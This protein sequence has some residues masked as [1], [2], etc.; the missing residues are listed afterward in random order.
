MVAI[1]H[2]ETSIVDRIYKAIEESNRR[3]VRLTRIGASDIGDECLRAIWYGWRGVASENIEGRILRLFETGH[4]QEARI[5]K[6]LKAAGLEVWDVQNRQQFTYNDE[7]GHFVVKLDGV[8]KGVPG[9]EKTPH[10]LEI[11]THNKSSFDDVMKSGVQKSKPDHYAQIHA[12]MAFSKIDRALYV[13]LCKNDEAYYVERVVEDRAYSAELKK[14][15]ITV[16]SA[17]IPPVRAFD[18]EK[19]Y[20]CRWC[21]SQKVCL[22]VEKPLKNCRTCERSEVGT[23]GTWICTLYK[24]TLSTEEQLVGCPEHSPIAM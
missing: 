9:A 5:I 7:S 13:A 23:D 18:P 17:T 16:L 10:V 20:S 2:A 11:K 24:T 4:L 1:P 15:I 19:Y 6:D 14:K 22:G 21:S 8:V 3:S 12:G